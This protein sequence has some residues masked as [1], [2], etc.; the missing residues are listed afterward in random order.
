MFGKIS[1]VLQVL[2]LIW[3]I[4]QTVRGLVKEAEIRRIREEE[5]AR[6]DGIERLKRAETEAE[7]EQA[8]QDIAKDSL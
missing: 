2:Q 8:I 3:K 5:T 7:R 6:A 1:V 4:I